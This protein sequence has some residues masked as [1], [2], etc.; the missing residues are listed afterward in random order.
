[1]NTSAQDTTIRLLT[2][3]AIVIGLLIPLFLINGIIEERKFLQEAVIQDISSSWGNDQVITGPIVTIPFSQPFENT[4]EHADGTTHVERGLK[5][6]MSHFI[7]DQAEQDALLEMDTLRRGIYEVPVYTAQCEMQANFSGFDC[8][9]WNEATQVHWE[10][11]FVSIGLAQNKISQAN[12]Q[13]NGQPTAALPGTPR[14]AP[15]TDGIH[16]KVP[17]DANGPL[18]FQLTTAM[19]GS[20]S[21]NLVPVA[22]NTTATLRSTWQAPSFTGSFL[23]EH[24]P[25]DFSEGFEVTWN[26]NELSRSI[27]AVLVDQRL[28]NVEEHFGVKLINEVTDYTK[29]E[30]STKYA[31]LF[32]VMAFVALLAI[33]LVRKHWLHPL[34]LGMIGLGLL[35]FYLLLL[36]LSEVVGFN[37]AYLIGTAAMIGLLSWYFAALFERLKVGLMMG[38]LLVLLYAFTFVLVQLVMYSLLVGSVALFVMLAVLMVLSRRLPRADRPGP[39]GAPHQPVS[40]ATP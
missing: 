5:A 2:M 15:V 7:P 18:Q 29:T 26:I 12:A 32:I 16:F 25:D 31:A 33:Q 40:P 38:G 10:Q 3:A 19:R 1:M 17:L 36:S 6:H 39:K 35:L 28:G 21:F 23:P 30:R 14:K 8:P 20:E 34:Q 37:V 27:P 13:A 4:V 9:E 22:R 11:A 24:R